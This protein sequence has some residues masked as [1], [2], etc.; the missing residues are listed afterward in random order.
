MRPALRRT[1]ARSMSVTVNGASEAGGVDPPMAAWLVA[2]N[3]RFGDVRHDHLSCLPARSELLVRTPSELSRREMAA[4]R[5]PCQRTYRFCPVGTS[6]CRRYRRDRFR[7]AVR[8]PLR[9][10]IIGPTN[11]VADVAS[12]QNFRSEAVSGASSHVAI[13]KPSGSASLWMV[14]SVKRYWCTSEPLV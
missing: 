10:P 3:T 6:C 8:N 12:V 13:R 2:D 1:A 7:N 14:R 9:G 5:V 4:S 11:R